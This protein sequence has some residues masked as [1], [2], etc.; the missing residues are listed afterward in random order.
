MTKCY[1]WSCTLKLLKKIQPFEFK[2]INKMFVFFS[3]HSGSFQS[4]HGELF[5]D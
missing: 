3:T 2:C 5:E 4:D 1:S